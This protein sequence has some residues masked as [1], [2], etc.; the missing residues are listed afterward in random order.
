MFLYK[1]EQDDNRYG[2]HKDGCHHEVPL[3]TECACKESDCQRQGLDLV[4][5]AE[6]QQRQQEVV[7]DPDDVQD[8]DGY[9][10]RF[11]DRHDDM[12]EYLRFRTSIDGSRFFKGNRNGFDET[13]EHE[14]GKR[15][16][17]SNIGEDHTATCIEDRYASSNF[18]TVEQFNQWEHNHLERNDQST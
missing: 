1:Q 8:D 2:S 17:E 7:P 10:Y 16:S 5:D 15:C 9:K 6:N 3:D 12:H 18:D 13:M 11:Q 4:T 14:Y